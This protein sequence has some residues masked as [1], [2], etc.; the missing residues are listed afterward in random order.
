MQ[1]PDRTKGISER[2]SCEL[3]LLTSDDD[4]KRYT[5]YYDEFIPEEHRLYNRIY[6]RKLEE[7]E[8]TYYKSLNCFK[9]IPE[10]PEL[11]TNHRY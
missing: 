1:F 8:I 3:D 10:Y 4:F 2:S 9:Y 7:K 11:I 5:D 6:W